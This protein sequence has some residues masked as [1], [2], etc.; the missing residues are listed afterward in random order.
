MDGGPVKKLAIN[1]CLAGLWIGAATFLE[2]GEPSWSLLL[3]ALGA[4]LR[5]AIGY[6]AKRVKQLPAIPVDE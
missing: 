1:A 3:G 2:G 4:G 6:G 5:F